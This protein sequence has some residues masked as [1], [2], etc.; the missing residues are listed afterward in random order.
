MAINV[1][2]RE[3]HRGDPPVVA[4]GIAGPQRGHH[5]ADAIGERRVGGERGLDVARQCEALG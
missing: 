5:H 1:P 3:R 4:Q 2:A